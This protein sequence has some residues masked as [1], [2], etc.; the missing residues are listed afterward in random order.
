MGNTSVLDQ[1]ADELFA[2]DYVWYFPGVTDLPPGPAGMKQMFRGIL[3]ANPDLR[4]TLADLI[5]DRDKTAIRCTMRR[6]D[7]DS[8][9][10][11]RG[12]NLVISRFVGDQVAEDWELISGWEDEE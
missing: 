5:V 1:V 7:P 6:T 3:A 10:P 9:K 4:F 11:Q 2:A 8:G 12:W